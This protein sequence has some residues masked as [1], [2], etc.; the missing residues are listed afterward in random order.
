MTTSSSPNEVRTLRQSMGIPTLVV[1]GLSYMVPMTVFTTYGIVNEITG[2]FL[3][4]AYLLTLLAMLFTA[5][6]YAFMG[7]MVP[8]AGSAY[9]YTRVGLGSGVG[10]L[11]GWT[12]MIDYILLPML[13]YLLIGL[14]LAERFP[15]VPA[16]VFSLIALV[17]VTGL[18]IVGVAAV[19]SANVVLVLLQV[20]FFAIFFVYAARAF[21]PS[22]QLLDPFVGPGF[23]ITSVAAGAAVLCLSFLG[24]DAVS[25]MAEEAREPRR[26]IPR[27]VILTTVIGG[28]FF[29][30]VSWFAHMA[31]P[32][33]M[34]GDAADV[35]AVEMLTRIGGNLLT[36]LFLAAY[37]TGALGSALASQASVSRILYAMGRDRLL[38]RQIFGTLSPRFRTPVGAII[39]VAVISLSAL[40]AD[41]DFVA[42][43]VSFGALSAFTMVNLSVIATYLV[44]AERRTVATYLLYGAIPAGGFVLTAWLWTSLTPVAVILGLV[45][46]AIGVSRLLWHTRMFSRPVPRMHL[47]E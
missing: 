39:V 32:D 38:P 15:S 33:V 24:F 35:A 18:N 44:H 8:S 19:K 16:W 46:V 21:D 30:A 45:W 4:T 34:T 2:G 7:K 5:C 27:A 22:A 3:S 29:V 14:Y 37:I 12:V 36:A 6:S 26:S 11:T 28:L 23:D 42:S 10:F 43:I 9:A 40:V 31:S 25:T 17:L 47:S 20:V 1:F 13:N 41:V